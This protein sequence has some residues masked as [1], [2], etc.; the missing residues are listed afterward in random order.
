MN[1]RMEGR[2]GIGGEAAAAAFGVVSKRGAKKI[3]RMRHQGVRPPSATQ[4]R[5]DSEN[6]SNCKNL[7]DK[8]NPVACGTM[9]S[10][11]YLPDKDIV[12]EEYDE[13][14]GSESDDDLLDLMSIPLSSQEDLSIHSQ[15]P[16]P[17]DFTIDEFQIVHS[18]QAAIQSH[19]AV[20]F[21]SADADH[22]CNNAAIIQQES[23]GSDDTTIGWTPAQLELP[24][25]AVEM[26][27]GQ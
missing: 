13:D 8:T 2:S 24:M 20:D 18:F 19:D 26:A 17:G 9:S 7:G 27:F 14:D 11:S 1:Q 6:R 4:Y 5:Y 23:Q 15:H 22:P 10:V 12:D 16:I 21:V 25:W 3:G